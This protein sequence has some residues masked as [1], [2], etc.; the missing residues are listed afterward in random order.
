M[1]KFEDRSQSH[2]KRNPFSPCLLLLLATLLSLLLSTAHAASVKFFIPSHPVTIALEKELQAIVTGYNALNPASTVE[3][4]RRGSE[5]SNLRDSL[6]AQMAGQP[7]DLFVIELSETRALENA[8]LSLRIPEELRASLTREMPDAILKSAKESGGKL[9]VLPFLIYQPVIAVD[10]EMLF[11]YDWNP[12]QLPKNTKELLRL[13]QFLDQ[14]MPPERDGPLLAI[15]TQG[16]RG[17]QMLEALYGGELWTR[18]PGGVRAERKALSLISQLRSWSDE[19][20]LTS[21]GMTS[22]Q[23]IEHFI[24]RRSPILLTTSD[25]LSFIGQQTQFRWSAIPVQNNSPALYSG[26]H[27][28]LA[29]ARPETLAFVRYLYSADVA[30]RWVSVSGARALKPEWRSVLEPVHKR[31]A[32]LARTKPGRV[33]GAD[34]EIMRIRSEWIQTLPELLGSFNERVPPEAALTGLEQRLSHPR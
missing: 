32:A 5:Y 15:P 9:L 26:G 27:L 4:V 17:L 31:M 20:K 29:N 11:R 23:S 6:S 18:E 13:L 21:L 1:L 7:P 24:A 34:P 12:H 19:L 8:K 10:Q 22:E 28:A 16:A 3:L 25:T 2:M 30:R 14:K 33:R